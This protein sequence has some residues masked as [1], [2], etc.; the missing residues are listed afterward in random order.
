MNDFE[1]LLFQTLILFIVVVTVLVAVSRIVAR[2]RAARR[3]ALVRSVAAHPA[4][5]ALNTWNPPTEKTR[6]IDRPGWDWTSATL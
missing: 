5:K 2:K 4:G 1:T 3:A 6:H